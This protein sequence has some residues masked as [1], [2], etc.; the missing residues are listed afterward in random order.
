MRVHYND[1]NRHNGTAEALFES[2]DDA[3]SAMKRHRAKM[4]S[5]YIELFFNGKATKGG[6]GGNNFSSGGGGGNSIGVGGGGMG[7]G[8]G[9]GGGGNFSRRI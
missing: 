3:Q 1:K 2:H 6:G 5:R 9:M 7:A 8:G 4:G